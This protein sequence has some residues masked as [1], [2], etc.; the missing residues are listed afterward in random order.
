MGVFSLWT[1]KEKYMDKRFERLYILKI[2]KGEMKKL[3]Q[4]CEDYRI[5]HNNVFE[6]ATKFHLIYGID[7]NGL[8]YLSQVMAL[9]GIDFNSLREFENYLSQFEEKN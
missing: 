9:R 7:G 5:R 8:I 3:K 1:C 2:K 4:I 6:G